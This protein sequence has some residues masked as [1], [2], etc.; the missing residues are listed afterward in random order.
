MPGAFQ[1]PKSPPPHSSTVAA[2]A[3]EDRLIK[4]INTFKGGFALYDADERLV[5][6]NDALS[7]FMPEVF[8]PVCGISRLEEVTRA[9]AAANDLDET[10]VQERLCL[11]RGPKEFSAERELKNGRWIETSVR[12]TPDGSTLFV[13]TDITAYKEAAAAL[14]HALE[15]ERELGQLQREFVSMTSHEFRTPLAIIDASAQRIQRRRDTLSGEEF[16]SLMQEIRLSVT[17]MVGLIDAILSTSWVDSGTLRYIPKPLDPGRIITRACDRQAAL[18]PR[19]HFAVD[20]AALPE[21]I[22]G[23]EIFLDQIVTN[24]VSNAVK[25][26]PAGGRIEVA[27]WTEGDGIAFSVKDHGVGIPAD[28]LPRLFQRFFRARTSTGISGTG[29][30]LHIV[31]R[32]VEMHGGAVGVTSVEG[33]GTTIT[34]RLPIHAPE[35]SSPPKPSASDHGVVF[36]R[37]SGI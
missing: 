29:I 25:Y 24:L 35:A 36:G 15:R 34:V 8:P 2:E 14:Q 9:I 17:R 21:P 6:I 11:Y 31:K 28:E 33:A 4:A 37:G 12:H 16:S 18:S 10:W 13:M 5:I 3:A 27:G 30:G 32:L 22:D 26:S 23:D 1:P 20:V 19:H 7:A